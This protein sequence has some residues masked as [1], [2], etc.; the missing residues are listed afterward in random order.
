MNGLEAMLRVHDGQPC[1]TQYTSIAMDKNT[2]AIR[3]AMLLRLDHVFYVGL[4][5]I[6]PD[7]SNSTHKIIS[8]QSPQRRPVGFMITR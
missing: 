5:D 6:S 8:F 4:F 7:A 2:V 1:V 3:S